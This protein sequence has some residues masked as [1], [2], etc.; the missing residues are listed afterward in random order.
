[1]P[2]TIPST[3]CFFKFLLLTGCRRGEAFNLQWTDI[4]LDEKQISFRKTKAKVDRRIPIELELLQVIM[5]FDR[6]QPKP[7]N[8]TAGWVTRLFG[9]YRDKVG[10]RKDLHLHSL[11]HTSATDLLRKGF[12]L[13]QIAEFLGHTNTNTT[14]IYTWVLSEDLRELAEAVTCVG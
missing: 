7:F 5:A 4:D 9:R 6:K 12:H 14:E 13:K 11:R 1:M 3:C 10:I 8:Y 2:S